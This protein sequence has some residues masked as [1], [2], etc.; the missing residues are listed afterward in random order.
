MKIYTI[1]CFYE[2]FAD[3]GGTSVTGSFRTLHEARAALENE[4][5]ERAQ[6]EWLFARALWYDENHED[7]RDHV[8]ENSGHED[9]A[10]FFHRYNDKSEFPE[11]I[12]A[13]LCRYL[14]DWLRAECSYHIFSSRPECQTYHYDIIENELMEGMPK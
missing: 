11:E 2:G 13:S 5:L 3:P 14:L 10:S 1:V 9:A 6:R 7:I 12:K 8:I 4:I